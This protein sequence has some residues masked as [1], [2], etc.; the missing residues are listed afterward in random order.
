MFIYRKF[1]FNVS[2]FLLF[3]YVRFKQFTFQKF[4]PEINEGFV[5]QKLASK[6]V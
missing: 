3:L 5:Q 4:H 1:I 6:P 2:I